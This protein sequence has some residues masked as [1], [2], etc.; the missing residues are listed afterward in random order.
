MASSIT[1]CSNSTNTDRKMMER[2]LE[3]SKKQYDK[4]STN[5][6][7]LTEDITKAKER[8]SHCTPRNINKKLKR[9]S[10]TIDRLKNT[11]Y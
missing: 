10:D 5:I 8:L 2:H 3:K 1:D 9:R 11:K 7:K 4:A 6:V